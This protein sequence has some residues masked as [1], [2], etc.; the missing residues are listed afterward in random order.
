M[1]KKKAK[2]KASARGKSASTA[3]RM[4][5]GLRASIVEKEKLWKIAA[6]QAKE[7]KEALKAAEQTLADTLDE[8]NAGQDMLPLEAGRKKT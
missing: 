5:K 3:I 6:D 2:K 4:L 1:A 7:R 8:L